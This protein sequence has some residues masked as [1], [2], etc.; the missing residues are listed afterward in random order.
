MTKPERSL[1]SV[2]QSWALSRRTSE[3]AREALVKAVDFEAN[4]N[5]AEVAG[6]LIEETTA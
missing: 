1:R 4:R 2:A 5:A 6:L 3:N